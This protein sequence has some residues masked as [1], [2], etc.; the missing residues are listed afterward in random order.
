MY[1]HGMVQNWRVRVSPE[2]LKKSVQVG[3]LGVRNLDSDQDAT[4]VSSMV[5]VVKQAD[6]P[7][8]DRCCGACYATSTASSTAAANRK[9]Q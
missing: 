6:I 1:Q 4:Y 8:I 9:R 2:V 3:Q 5:A 7:R